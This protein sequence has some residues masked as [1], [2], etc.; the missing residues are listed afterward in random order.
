M[1]RTFFL[2]LIILFFTI[3]L[4]SQ[5]LEFKHFSTD[6]GL[7][8]SEVYCQLQ[9]DKGYMWFG[10]SRGLSRYDGYQFV[11][12]TASDGLPSN[13]IIK[14]FKGRFGKIW[15][16]NYDGSLSYYE[17]GKFEIYEYN[18]TL[19]K[20][21]KKYYLNNLLIDKDT[22][23]WIMPSLG[24]I[25]KINKSGRIFD[26]TPEKDERC[27][28]F[29]DEEFGIVS[30]SIYSSNKSDSVR[31][32]VDENEY[33]LYGTENGFRKNVVKTSDNSFLISIGQNLYHIKNGFIFDHISYKNEISGILI[34]KNKNIWISV[35]YEGIYSYS[36][37][38]FNSIPERYLFGQSPIQVFQDNQNGY[39][40]STT[41]N[42]VF[43][44]PSFQFI[45][46]K[47][48]GIPLFNI[49][50]LKIFDNTLYFSTYDRQVVKSKLYNHK[51]L[52][53]ESLQLREGRDY[54][55]L[56]IIATKDSSIWFL[57]KEL[58]RYKND[59]YTVTD[60]ISRSY[61][62]FSKNNDIY[63][64]T[65]DGMFIFSENTEFFFYD[66]FPVSNAIFV[67]NN[68][69]V[70][71]GSIN[72]L[73]RFK[74]KK[75]KYLGDEIPH[76]KHRVNDLTQY[77]KYIVIAT[78]GN[79]LLFYNPKNNY[80]KQIQETDGLNSNFVNIVFVDGKNLWVGTNS[81]LCKINI[82]SKYD[83]IQVFTTQFDNLDGLNTNEIKDIDKNGD[84]IFLGT[85][86]GLISFY[87]DKLEKNK[88]PPNLR[89]DSIMVNKE[90][91]V[92]DSL[93]KFS[94]DKNTFTVYFKGISY[95]AGDKVIYKYKL[96]GYDDKW[97]ETRDR[98]LRF[99]NLL[100]GEYSLKLL[101]SADGILWN[102]KPIVFDFVIKKKFTKTVIFYFLIL[103]LFFV[104]AVVILVLRFTQLE[105]DL[106]QKRKMMRSEQKALR[107]QMNPHFLFNALNSI[108]RYILENDS[109]NA[110]FYLT[111][112]AL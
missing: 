56:D 28:Y 19:I 98:I 40:L 66:N 55:I 45:S 53:V 74:N 29:K 81:G 52:S 94:S 5:Q 47:K 104:I 99:P 33:F 22:S 6:N 36:N 103:F 80:I 88:F 96:D 79:G 82:I 12:Y 62:L 106:K 11:N 109:E 46:Y 110:D 61:R 38:N 57:G 4:F 20:I 68:K 17:D 3:N 51:I 65:N 34:D 91:I 71:I 59:E 1:K 39:W 77:E 97:V 13:S 87:P 41:E 31:L 75:F 92:L 58:I 60:T 32:E 43:Y 8:S 89:I 37:D 108:R 85:S 102:F 44:T 14:M 25:F 84:C 67:D 63:S 83:S 30:S 112:F 35:L 78:N 54:S 111:S 10:T 100:P 95:S 49:I 50:S 90:T 42:G 70:W 69:T 72:G 9:D 86:Q 26:E 105:K 27:F 73:F 93:M 101:S 16:S 48:F 23:L 7:A 18:D 15:F 2:L 24:G 76:L 64:C 21:D 107:S